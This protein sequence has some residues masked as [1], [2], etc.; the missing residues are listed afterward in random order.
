MSLR[1]MY[2]V[3]IWHVSST[4]L[5]PP[6][7]GLPEKHSAID[8][9]TNFSELLYLLLSLLPLF[10]SI[11]LFFCHSV[12]LLLPSLHGRSTLSKLSL[13]HSRFS[14]SQMSEKWPKITFRF[15]SH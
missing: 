1:T 11:S 3:V 12:F 14:V 9:A 5:V 6:W 4:S 10:P 7:M 15:Y 2:A 8:E 13:S